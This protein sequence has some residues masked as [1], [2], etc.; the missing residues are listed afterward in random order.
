MIAISL[1]SRHKS[2]FRP[3]Q[4][5]T[6]GTLGRSIF[7]QHYCHVILTAPTRPTSGGSIVVY[8]CR[9]AIL[10][11]PTGP[12]Q[13]TGWFDLSSFL[14]SR[15]SDYRSLWCGLKT[16]NKPV[17]WSTHRKN[18]KRKLYCSSIFRWLFDVRLGVTIFVLQFNFQVIVWH[19]VGG[20]YF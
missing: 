20:N 13:Y 8:Y 17:Y 14:L 1:Q 9:H 2:R 12:I 6:A 15:N 5:S 7:L 16:E 4:S 10:I 18:V 3:Q 11:A 19:P